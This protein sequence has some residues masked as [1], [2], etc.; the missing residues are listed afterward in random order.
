MIKKLWIPFLL[1]V[2]TGTVIATSASASSYRR[3]S[4]NK[5][6]T[7]EQFNFDANDISSEIVLD[8]QKDAIY[9]QVL[10]FGTKTRS[11]IYDVNLYVYHGEQALYMLFDVYDTFIRINAWRKPL[12]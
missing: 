9:T 11:G 3:Y 1:L 4:E 12:L 2:S 6:A 7:D 8:G 10:D 5:T